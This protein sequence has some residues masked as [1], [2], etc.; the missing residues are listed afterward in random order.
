MSATKPAK[1]ARVGGVIRVGRWELELDVTV[2]DGRDWFC[3]PVG[4]SRCGRVLVD[5]GPMGLDCMTWHVQH[6]HFA[7]LVEG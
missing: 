4:G 5:F 6:V 3:C 1:P 2:V 7:Y